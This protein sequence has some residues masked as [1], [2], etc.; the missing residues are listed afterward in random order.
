MNKT[1]DEAVKRV[2]VKVFGFSDVERHALNTV[3]RLSEARRTAYALWVE[4]APDAAEI[5]LIDGDSWEAALELANPAHDSPKLIWVGD[6]APA[7]ASLVVA[8]PLQWATVIDGMDALLAAADAD[9]GTD[10]DLDLDPDGATGPTPLELRLTDPDVFA[11]LVADADSGAR[12]YLRAKL[13]REG[14]MQV[15]EASTGA[16]ALHLLDTRHYKLVVLDLDLPDTDSWQLVRQVG[17]SRPAVDFLLL[18]G[19][20]VS[21]VDGVRGWFAGARACLRK[22][23]HPGKLKQLLR[24]AH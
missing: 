4:S 23:L 14:L 7:R 3:F 18:T 19:S 5:A 13:A 15:D 1:D 11:V 20:R 16:Q 9:L 17:E 6:K 2:F 22:P 21:W 12:L 10:I 24:N 8:R